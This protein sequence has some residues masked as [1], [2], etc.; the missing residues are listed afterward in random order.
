M[1]ADH[2]KRVNALLAE[3]ID[4]P[5]AE[6]AALLDVLCASDDALRAELLGLLAHEHALPDSVPAHLVDVW[7]RD[8]DGDQWIGRRIGAFIVEERLGIGGSS[9]VF[10][11]RR[12]GDFSQRVAI[13]LLRTA[14]G[15]AVVTRF[16]REREILAAL[17]HPNIA[18]LYDAGSSADGTPTSVEVTARDCA[19][20]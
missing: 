9:V 18:Q 13:K 2:W 4:V 3:L 10:R 19:T 7:A 14:A 12:D 15:D 11:A 8:Q 5:E 16:L 20:G 1:K 17:H 6:R